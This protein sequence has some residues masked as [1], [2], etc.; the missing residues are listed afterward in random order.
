MYLKTKSTDSEN[1]LSTSPLRFLDRLI[2]RTSC[3]TLSLELRESKYFSI[4]FTLLLEKS[5]IL[6]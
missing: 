1:Q 4:V 2:R 6:D 3:D 5:K